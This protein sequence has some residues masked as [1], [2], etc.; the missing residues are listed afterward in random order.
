MKFKNLLLQFDWASLNL[1]WCK[2][3]LVEGNCS[4]EGTCPFQRED[5]SKI[6]KILDKI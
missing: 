3:S 6:A 1:I 5:N 2:T 4:N